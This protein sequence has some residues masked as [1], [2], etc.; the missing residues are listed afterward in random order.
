[1]KFFLRA[2]LLGSLCLAGPA[3]AQTTPPASVQI[4]APDSAGIAAVVN[5]QVITTQDVAAR[6][7]LLAV[8]MG[9][10]PV[11]AVIG[12]LAPQVTAQLID[13]TLQLQ[14]INKLSVTV[15]D[16]DV[17]AAIAHIEQNN[18]M[19]Q[20]ALRTRLTAM[21]VPFSTLLAQIR[22]ELGWQAVLHQV[23]GPGLA[24]TPGDMAAEKA[25]LQAQLGSTQYHLAEIFVPVSDPSDDSAAQTFANT[26][27]AQLRT[28]APFPVVAAEFSQA[29]TALSGGDLGYIQ[30]SQMD[31][32]VAATVQSMPVGAISNPI[33]VPGGYEIVQLQDK[34]EIG[35]QPQT[36]ISLRQV[37]ANYPSPI[38]NGQVG[39]AQA[40]VITKLAAQV[41]SITSCDGITALNT[42]Y[43]NIHPAD[44][45]PVALAT[46]TPA[47]FQKLLGSLPLNTPSPPL[48]QQSGVSVVMVCSRGQQSA[49]LP[50]DQDIANMIVNRRVD[51]ESQ[52]L[53]DI[54]R[55]RAVITQSN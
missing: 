33:R 12:R 37:W 32:A 51:L 9:I 10:N 49:I 16:D 24:P 28:G 2:V 29:Q 14:E 21:G 7:R 26:V 53:L 48:I 23:L 41:K 22:V 4:G 19:P 36:V 25:A 43:G 20:G 47:N 54:L 1:M 44:P 50:S 35:N 11:P 8:T 18:N 15:S 3:L 13:Q 45:G 34:H 52:Q 42:Q 5:S 6:A 39:P 55:H 46:V 30:L 40:A 31:P 38:E 27:I 17:A